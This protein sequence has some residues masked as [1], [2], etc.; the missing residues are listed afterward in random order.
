MS[1]VRYTSRALDDIDALL[2]FMAEQ[3]MAGRG[4]AFVDRVYSACESL[5]IFP[6]RGRL[7]PEF[8]P[9]IRSI[10][11]SPVVAFYR[12]I[13]EDAENGATVEVLRI[14]D[15]RRD[16]RTVFFTG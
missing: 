2:L 16:L 9:G 15:G 13:D 12:V 10:P 6:Q 4:A 14:I 5:E 8:G 11:V 1:K 7:R 3:N